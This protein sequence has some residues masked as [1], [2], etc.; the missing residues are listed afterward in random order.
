MYFRYS[1]NLFLYKQVQ[2]SCKT[3][4][5]CLNRNGG[6]K[7]S[8]RFRMEQRKVKEHSWQRALRGIIV[9]VALKKWLYPGGFLKEEKGSSNFAQEP[10]PW[11]LINRNHSQIKCSPNNKDN[12][13][14]PQCL[15]LNTILSYILYIF[16]TAT[17]EWK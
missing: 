10:P 17:K 12:W 11:Q 4:L 3:R 1:L 8:L 6:R 5:M 2:L 13:G 14:I 7:K 15:S 9:P 16:S